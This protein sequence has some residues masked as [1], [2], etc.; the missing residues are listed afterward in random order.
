MKISLFSKKI[1]MFDLDGTL[2]KSKAILDQE[3]ASLLCRLLEKKIVA[4]MGGGNYPQFKN[5]FLKYLPGSKEQFKNLF[6]LPV[7]GGSLYKYHNNRWYLVYSNVLTL[8]EKKK[9]FAAFKKAFLHTKYAPPQ[10]TYGKII[11]DRKSQ[12][13]FSALGQKAPLDKKKEWHKSFDIRPKLQKIL[14]KYLPDFEVRLGGLTSIDI[15]KKGIDKAYGVKQIA[16]LLSIPKKDIVYIGDALYKGG[17]DYAVKRAGIDTLP[18]KDEEETKQFIRFLLLKKL[19]KKSALLKAETNPIIQPIQRSEWQAWQTFNPGV[20]LLEDNVH[21]LYRAIGAD[22]LSRFGYAC[23]SDGFKIDERLPYPVFEH[24]LTPGSFN[25]WS[26][27]SGGSFGGAEDP[28]IVQVDEEDT[29]YMTY[30]ACDAGLRMGL[31]SIKVKDFLSKKWN[32]KSPK[33]ISPPGE[34]HKNWVI[35]PEKIKGKYAILH[36]ISPEIGIAYFDSLEFDGLTYIQ[37]NYN[38]KC[39]RKNGCY[40]EGYVRGIGAPPI[41]TKYGWL[42]FYHALEKND[43]SKYKVGAMLLDLNDPTKILFRS[44]EPILEP[45][46][47]YENEGFKAGIVYV[48]GAVVKDSK[49]MIYYGGADSYVNL[50]HVD[51]E[52]FLKNLIQTQKPKL[53]RI[54][55]KK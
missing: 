49:L 36:S 45:D 7:S 48:S 10:K 28:R 29:L 38:G 31:T 22:S 16:K 44:K 3:M 8:R 42:I 39:E 15:T 1:I 50:A 9:V 47:W 18:V 24:G 13:T 27:A 46:E 43:S 32:W 5:Q 11:E 34:T 14:K 54:T 37:S 20:I 41:K 52:E 53:K 51:M 55:H 33:L 26:F 2:T 23:S 12:I 4:V 35:F 21:F 19:V 40:W 6:L 25:C 17:N 30:T